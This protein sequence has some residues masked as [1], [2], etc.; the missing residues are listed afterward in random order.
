MALI[1]KIKILALSFMMSVGSL[2]AWASEEEHAK[3]DAGKFAMEEVNDMHEWHIMTIGE[4]HISIPLPILLYSEHSG[5]HAFFSSK[6]EHGHAAYKGFE[7]AHEGAHEGRIVETLANGEVY[8]PWDF[9]ITKVVVGLLLSVLILL[10]VFLAVAKSMKANEGKAPRGLQ[11]AMEPFIGFVKDDI[12]VPCIGEERYEKYMPYLLTVFFF[13]LFNN[14]IGLI[15][16]PPFG[17]NVT[18]NI[19]ITLCLAA[20]TFVLTTVS[21]NHHYW[22]EIYNPDVPWWMKYPV[23]LMPFIELLGMIIKPIV[24]MI[25]LFANI[26]AGHLVVAVFVALIFVFSNIMGEIAGIGVS[27]LSV[28]LSVFIKMLDLLVA[29]I[30]AFV[31][32]LLSAIYIGTATSPSHP[33][34]GEG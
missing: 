30:Q 17:A 8:V 16:I 27:P 25:R 14:L 18:G 9:S 33:P 22:K 15:P 23:P 32:T 26:F 20:F 12:A 24:L 7:L 5:F 11:N 29:F 31:F 2:A 19:S 10:W 1:N 6:F 34:Q 21:A 3:F 13:I 4:H 28:G